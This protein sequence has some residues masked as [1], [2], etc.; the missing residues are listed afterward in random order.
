MPRLRRQMYK[1]LCHCKL[2]L[3]PSPTRPHPPSPPAPTSN[4]NR[5]ERKVDMTG[6]GQV[7]ETLDWEKKKRGNEKLH[8]KSFFFFFIANNQR[9][10]FFY[11]TWCHF[12]TFF[13]SLHPFLR[14]HDLISMS[15]LFL[16]GWQRPRLASFLGTCLLSILS[17]TTLSMKTSEG[18]GPDEEF[19]PQSVQPDYY[20]SWRNNLNQST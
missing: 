7:E 3:W 13:P 12:F 17:Y 18:Y 16:C 20:F 4:P 15:W 8:W 14:T 10:Y 19:G 9:S 1:E 6:G 5:M 2:S 11:C